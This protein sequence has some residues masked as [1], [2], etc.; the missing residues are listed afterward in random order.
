[1]RMR[2]VVDFP[3][4]FGPMSPMICPSG[5]WRSILSSEKNRYFFPTPLRSIARRVIWFPSL[6]FG[7]RLHEADWL[8]LSDEYLIA[9]R[10]ALPAPDAVAVPA[11]AA[12]RRG[13][14]PGQHANLSLV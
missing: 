10:C 1:M 5:S 12:A 14:R 6:R 13:L 2:M 8:V 4:P 7:R 9:R 11:R 3:A